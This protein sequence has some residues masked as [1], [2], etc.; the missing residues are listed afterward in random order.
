LALP[1]NS[2]SDGLDLP[3]LRLISKKSNFN[4]YDCRTHMAAPA[5]KRIPTQANSID[6]VVDRL[7]AIVQ[8]ASESNSRTGYFAALYRKV[9]L[10]VREGI[11]KGLFE[12]P[13]R[14]A[15]FDVVFANRYLDA[16]DAFRAGN[17]TSS[18]W[19]LAFQSTADYWPIVLQT[20]L[21]PSR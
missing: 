1:G 8:W 15:R 5:L 3:F 17:P 18:C 9:T 16:F 10:S 7:S 12:D 20:F 21:L 14:M 6:E 11:H 13:V 19:K 4:P 2:G